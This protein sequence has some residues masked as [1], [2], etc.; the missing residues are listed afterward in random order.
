MA[1]LPGQSGADMDGKLSK[2]KVINDTT[3]CVY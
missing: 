1:P 2:A 3:W